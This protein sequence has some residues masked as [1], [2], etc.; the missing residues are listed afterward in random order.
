MSALDLRPGEVLLHDAT[1]WFNVSADNARTL[2]GVLLGR[3]VSGRPRFR[4][5]RA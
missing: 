3:R 2:K 5:S 1:R 4:R